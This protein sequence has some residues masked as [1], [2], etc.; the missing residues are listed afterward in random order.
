MQ[1]TLI[2]GVTTFLEKLDIVQKLTKLSLLRYLKLKTIDHQPIL[3]ISF[4]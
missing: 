3:K 1:M 2:K 4:D